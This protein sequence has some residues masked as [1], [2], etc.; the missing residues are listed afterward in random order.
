[1]IAWVIAFGSYKIEKGKVTGEV[2]DSEDN[3][4]IIGLSFLQRQV[5]TG[6]QREWRE[7]LSGQAVILHFG[8]PR[9]KNVFTN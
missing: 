5:G 7:R 9:R 6:N 3:V 4:F 8:T 1:V 2:K